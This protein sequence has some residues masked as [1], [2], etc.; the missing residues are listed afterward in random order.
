[1]AK[2][3]SKSNL[4]AAARAELYNQLA[5]ML[6]AGL[7]LE[8]S[9]TTISNKQDQNTAAIKQALIKVRGG[10]D[11]T[12][13]GQS[14]RLFDGADLQAIRAAELG[15]RLAPTLAR[16][17]TSHSARVIRAQRIKSRLALP[18]AV[19]VLAAF[20]G[21]LPALVADHITVSQ[22]LLGVV[23]FLGRL[24]LL[25]WLLWRLPA[26]VRRQQRDQ[27]NWLDTLLI[28]LPIFGRYHVRRQVL[29]VL[30]AFEMLYT[31]GVPADQALQTARRST[32]NGY[33]RESFADT[34]DRM[35]QG[36]SL[37]DAFSGGE[38]LTEQARHMINSGDAAGSLSEMLQRFWTLESEALAVF[39]EQVSEWLPRLIYALIAGWM[40]SNI[41]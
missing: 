30:D 3:A 24:A 35:R 6:N 32:T 1:M 20:V 18:I 10:A 38:Y 33:V 23:W 11:F 28:R 13:A 8:Q 2:R 36:A 9:L 21:P 19:L 7:T 41:L 25:G 16:M 37:S 29:Q 26:W 31:A 4:D 12:T 17:S 22:Y 39:D 15:G 27:G 34:L 14:V 40:V 5:T